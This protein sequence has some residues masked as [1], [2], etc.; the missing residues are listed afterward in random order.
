MFEKYF[1]RA[2]EMIDFPHFVLKDDAMW[3]INRNMRE[4]LL[5]NNGFIIVS[6]RMW[7]AAAGSDMKGKP[8]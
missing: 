5:M 2:Y 6:A 1:N 4:W 7:I 8:S 3:T